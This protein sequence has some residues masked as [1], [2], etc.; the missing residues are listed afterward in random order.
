MDPAPSELHRAVDDKGDL[1]L[2]ADEWNRLCVE[3][4]VSPRRLDVLRCLIERAL[5]DKQIAHALDMS[6]GTVHNHMANLR[7]AFRASTRVQIVERALAFV[8]CPDAPPR[9]GR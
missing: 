4:H 9:R 3:F 7:A 2:S 6:N 5:S 1:R 8:R